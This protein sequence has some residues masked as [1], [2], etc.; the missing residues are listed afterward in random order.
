MNYENDIKIDMDALDLE[1]FEQPEKM[2]KYSSH[3]AD[4]RR[5]LD[6]AKEKLELIKAELDSEIR[7][8]APSKYGLEKFTEGAITSIILKDKKYISANQTMN[9]AKYDLDIAQAAVIAIAQRKDALENLVKLF[10][11]QYFAGPKVPRDLSREAM[12][13]AEKDHI[14][15]NIKI[16]RGK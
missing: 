9:D 10:L 7:K 4:M 6:L 14:K 15:D 3:A 13:K 5:K 2:F 1:W 8:S 16:E 12:K 11:G